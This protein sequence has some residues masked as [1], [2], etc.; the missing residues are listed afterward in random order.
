VGSGENNTE[1]AS[2]TKIFFVQAVGQS[3]V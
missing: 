1:Y 3:N 2:G